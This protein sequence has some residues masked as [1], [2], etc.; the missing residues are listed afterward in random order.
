MRLV[1]EINGLST[2]AYAV[3]K[4]VKIAAINADGE[5]MSTREFVNGFIEP[6]TGT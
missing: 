5:V 4:C 2:L 1:K 3:S 6:V